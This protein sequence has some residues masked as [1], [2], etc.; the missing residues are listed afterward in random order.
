MKRFQSRIYTRIWNRINKQN[1]N[2][3]CIITGSTGSGKSYSALKMAQTL[4]PNFTINNVV[5]R[6]DQFMALINNGGLKKGSIVVFD[7]AGVGMPAREWYSI[8]NKMLSYV[9]QTFRFMNLGVIFTTPSIGF[10]DAQARRLFHTFIETEEVDRKNKRVRARVKEMQHNPQLDKIYFKNPRKHKS[11][12]LMVSHIFVGKPSE[13][14]VKAYEER[15]GKYAKHLF[16]EIH[17]DIDETKKAV[18]RVLLTDEEVIKIVLKKLKPKEVTTSKIAAMTDIAESRAR[19]IRA[20][21]KLG[22]G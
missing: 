11:G 1:R 10:I 13:D 2:W 20:K 8:S 14:L 3:L 17:E 21:I 15:K 19:K 6:P 9:L 16:E 5:F 22:L 7:E 12:L 4:D 18:E